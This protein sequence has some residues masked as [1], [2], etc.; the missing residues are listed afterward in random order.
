MGQGTPLPEKTSPWLCPRPQMPQQG[1][2]PTAM[3]SEQER[4]SEMHTC[5]SMMEQGV[6]PGWP[7]V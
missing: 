1:G 4:Q 7:V 3:C 2:P 5:N 6:G